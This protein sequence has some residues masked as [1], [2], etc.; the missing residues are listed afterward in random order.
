MIGR[1][2]YIA[3]ALSFVM[4][5]ASADESFHVFA[6]SRT[7]GK[8]FVVRAV[9]ENDKLDLRVAKT[10][11]LGFPAATIVANPTRRLLYVAAARTEES[12]TPGAV[13][14][15]G[16]DG[17]I[18]KRSPVEF[19]H[20][21]AYLSI[22][23]SAR[24]LLGA[25]YRDGQVDVYRLKDDG[26]VGQRVCGL[27]EGRRNA[28]CV[29]PS[30]DNRFVYIPYVKDT[31]AIFQYAF[32]GKTGKLTP[33]LQ[34]NAEPPADTGPR[35][36]A[37]HPHLPIVY[38]SNEQHLGVSVY[39]RSDSGDLRLH[40]ICDAVEEKTPWQGVSSSDIVITPDGK[41]LF[42][43]IRGHTREFDW[44]SRYKVLSD[45]KVELLGLTP[46]D[47]IPWGL[48]L[49]PDGEYLLATAYQDGTLTAF[50]IGKDGSLSRSASVEWEKGISDLVTLP[51]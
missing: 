26:G 21:Y 2:L 41:Y 25:N 1:T 33:L 18:A 32:D 39:T 43:G 36:M 37:Y 23:R 15:V 19:R 40:Q 51:Y 47:K 20:G 9:V 38:F 45:G 44:V 30:P 12:E 46:S 13:L 4:P 22:D 5:C 50:K 35:H 16:K 28:H 3:L 8:L 17:G 6:P 49:S 42:A 29:L 27:A 7:S 31:N 34:K 14:H 10:M 24:F 48:A 11:E